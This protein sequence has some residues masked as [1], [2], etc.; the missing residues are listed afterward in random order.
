MGMYPLAFPEILEYLGFA[1]I[2]VLHFFFNVLN[3]RMIL[4]AQSFKFEARFPIHLE[5]IFEDKYLFALVL[6]LMI[7]I[8]FKIILFISDKIY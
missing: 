1:L 2:H 5:F 7:S 3:T 6:A 8:L 4:F